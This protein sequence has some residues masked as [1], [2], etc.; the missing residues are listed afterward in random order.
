MAAILV[1]LVRQVDN[2][3]S[4][5]G[6][7]LHAYSATSAKRFNDNGLVVFEPYS[8]YAASHYGAKTVA[9]SIA[10]FRLAPV[11]I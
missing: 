10:A 2:R 3:D 6:T 7:F 4:A 1:Q 5:E 9:Y 8:F 11:S